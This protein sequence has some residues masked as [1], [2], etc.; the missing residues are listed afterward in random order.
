MVR[1]SVVA[2]TAE[3]I[4]PIC[5]TGFT[6][7]RIASAFQPGKVQDGDFVVHARISGAQFGPDRF[8][9]AGGQC[10]DLLLI[11]ALQGHTDQGLG[12]GRP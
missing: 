4:F 10:C 6:H 9:Q 7:Q 11:S 3:S 12:T 2:K 5:R 1:N 8:R